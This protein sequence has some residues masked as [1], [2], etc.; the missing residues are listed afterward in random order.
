MRTIWNLDWTNELFSS[1]FRLRSNGWHTFAL[2]TVCLH[3]FNR[4]NLMHSYCVHNNKYCRW[5]SCTGC[6][7]GKRNRFRLNPTTRVCWHKYNINFASLHA[8]HMRTVWFL[9]AVKT[10]YDACRN[11]DL[12]GGSHSRK[13]CS[14]TS[15]VRCIYAYSIYVE[16]ANM[17]SSI[18]VSATKI[19]S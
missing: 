11:N 8:T 17:S 12:R 3:D 6:I 14:P 13:K 19:V 18:S 4:F 2:I 1:I 5:R 15:H 9:R 10:T 16:C 7:M